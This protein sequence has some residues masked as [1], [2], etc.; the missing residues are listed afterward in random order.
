MT[1][2]LATHRVDGT[3]TPVLSV[4]GRHW[5]LADVA[6]EALRPEPARGLMN[7]FDHWERTEPTLVEAAERLADGTD[8]TRPL[9][10]PAALEDV[11]TPLQ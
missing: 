6:P 1:F 10:A 3:P 9:P 8:T 2:S 4:D 7:V 11:L 5:A